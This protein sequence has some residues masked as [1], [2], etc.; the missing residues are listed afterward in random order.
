MSR[1]SVKCLVFQKTFIYVDVYYVKLQLLVEMRFS[2][3]LGVLKGGL[4]QSA[5]PRG[6][7]ERLRA[8]QSVSELVV[9][10]AGAVAVVVAVL[11]AVIRPLVV[12]GCRVIRE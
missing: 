6:S 10:V 7:L 12:A 2:V 1:K 4:H 3:L 11:V 8:L 9:A 5:S